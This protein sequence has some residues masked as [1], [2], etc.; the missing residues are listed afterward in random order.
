MNIPCTSYFDGFFPG[1]GGFD[2]IPVLVDFREHVRTSV[3]KWRSCTTWRGRSS[4]PSFMGPWLAAWA[5]AP[6]KSRGSYVSGLV[7]VYTLRTWKW[8]LI[9]DLPIKNGDFPAFFVCLPEGNVV[10][11]Y[12]LIGDVFGESLKNGCF[13]KMGIPREMA[14]TQGKYMN[15]MISY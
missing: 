10:L 1:Y 8:L 14:N 9:V 12:L 7:N 2:K 3:F 5:F 13:W 6:R 15:M 4:I 11:G